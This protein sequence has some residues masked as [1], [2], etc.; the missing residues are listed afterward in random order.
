MKGLSSKKQRTALSRREMLTG[1]SATLAASVAGIL[2]ASS[3]SHASDVFPPE[4][5]SNPGPAAAVDESAN[6]T[7]IDPEHIFI[8]KPVKNPVTVVTEPV[9]GST[10]PLQLTYVESVDG[11]Y[12][13]VGVR[14]PAGNGPFP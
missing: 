9:L 2:F 14:K 11:M 1:T 12:A 5:T 3:S 7:S 4:P 6:N 13:P 10:I 8:P